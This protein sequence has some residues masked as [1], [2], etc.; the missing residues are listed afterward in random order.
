M[1]IWRVIVLTFAFDASG[2]ERTTLLSV[3][4]F[5]SSAEDWVTFSEAWTNRLSQEG[6]KCF[7]AV[8]ANAFRGE[9]EPFRDRSDK[10][11]WRERLFSDLMDILTQV[12]ER[13]ALSP[14]AM[15]KGGKNW[16]RKKDCLGTH[17][18]RS[19]LCFS[20]L[21]YESEYF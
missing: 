9:F 21:S 1:L 11:Q 10:V 16:E 14:T 12:V 4:G 13:A 6:I 17:R 7:H 3:A 15:E 8:D 18:E 20:T 2:D 19:P 5:V